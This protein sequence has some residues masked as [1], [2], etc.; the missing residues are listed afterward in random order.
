[1][2]WPTLERL[3]GASAEGN[4]NYLAKQEAELSRCL[5][6]WRIG[7]LQAL[8]GVVK[9][10]ARTYRV[11]VGPGGSYSNDILRMVHDILATEICKE[12]PGIEVQKGGGIDILVVTWDPAPLGLQ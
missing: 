1:M 8:N 11:L 12:I 5:I 9:S 10:N 6:S 7:V 2:K 4:R 3:R